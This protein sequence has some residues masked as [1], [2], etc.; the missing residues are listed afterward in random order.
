MNRITLVLLTGLLLLAT[1]TVVSQE[2]KKSSKDKKAE[3]ELKK[4][5]EQQLREAQWKVFQV[6]AQEQKFIVEF[7]RV[8][9]TR[10]GMVYNLSPRTNFIAISGDKVVVQVETNEYLASNGL[11]G[12]TVQGSLSNYKYEPP[13][14][15]KGSIQISFNVT[16][17][18]T[19][20][21]TNVQINVGSEGYSYV[22]IGN[23]PTIY[24]N[25]KSLEESEAL[26]GGSF[27]N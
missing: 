15:E 16:S 12:V 2:E 4:Q 9:D 6:L 23:S 3:R 11:G 5:E 22:T 21:G 18:N 24:G 25:F 10:T 1:L 8:T 17:E 14:N 19:F 20:R 26:V 27:L 13:K 7:A